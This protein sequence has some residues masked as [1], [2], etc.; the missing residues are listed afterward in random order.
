M[1][2]KKLLANE[3]VEKPPARTGL[4]K[5]GSM[6]AQRTNLGIEV[7]CTRDR[8][9]V[10]HVVALKWFVPAAIEKFGPARYS[11]KS[12]DFGGFLQSR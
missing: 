11:S 10:R 4:R 5:F 9:V 6:S 7:E 12:T 8:R 3:A 2:P 1:R